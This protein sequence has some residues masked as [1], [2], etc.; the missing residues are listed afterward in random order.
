ML[1]P[2]RLSNITVPQVRI[3]IRKRKFDHPAVSASLWQSPAGQ[4]AMFVTNSS[5]KEAESVFHAEIKPD[6]VVYFKNDGSTYSKPFNGDKIVLPPFS[7]A[8]LVESSA[9]K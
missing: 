2:P 3:G 8:A 6:T 9:K 5:G 4:K 7:V 1:R